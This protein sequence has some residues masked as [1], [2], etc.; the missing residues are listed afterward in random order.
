M[1][2]CLQARVHP[3]SSRGSEP[4]ARHPRPTHAYLWTS[5]SSLIHSFILYKY[6]CVYTYTYTYRC[7]A[8][9]PFPSLATH[10]VFS[11]CSLLPRAPPPTPPPSRNHALPFFSSSS[12]PRSGSKPG[13]SAVWRVFCECIPRSSSRNSSWYPGTVRTSEKI[14]DPSW[15]PIGW[16][17]AITEYFV[18]IFLGLI[19][20]LRP[21]SQVW[22][23]CGGSVLVWR[24]RDRLGATVCLYWII[25]RTCR[26]E[27]WRIL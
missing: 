1:C 10:T 14:S 12:L 6:V 4:R 22:L 7:R 21:S 26:A 23:D 5:L 11:S 18:V 3:H 25:P 16:S 15:V 27:A 24:A 8:C 2:S 9:A 20:L 13:S 19:L 17:T